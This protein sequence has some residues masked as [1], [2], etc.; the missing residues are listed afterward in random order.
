M[1]KIAT[2]KCPTCGEVF[3]VYEATDAAA[4]GQLAIAV[5]PRGERT[6]A[7]GE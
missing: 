1:R 3:I 4:Y 7:S 2:V 6:A 5:V